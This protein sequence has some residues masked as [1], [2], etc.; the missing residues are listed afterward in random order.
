MFD[1]LHHTLRHCRGVHGGCAWHLR[2]AGCNVKGFEQSRTVLGVAAGCSRLSELWEHGSAPQLK[3]AVHVVC[4]GGL[5]GQV[6]Y[7]PRQ[8]DC[9]SAAMT[10]VGAHQVGGC[11]QQS[12]G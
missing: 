8:A 3:A 6:A 11:D 1:A 9:T 10:T 4:K 12:R 7:F 2:S 5:A